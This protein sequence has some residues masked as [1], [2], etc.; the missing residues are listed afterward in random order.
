MTPKSP[1]K[2]DSKALR[3]YKQILASIPEKTWKKET[4]F[5]AGILIPLCITNNKPSILFTVRSSTLR[6]H[7]GEVSFPGGKRDQ[8]DVDI[9]ATA[10]RETEEEISI[11][12]EAVEYLGTFISVP[13]K[14]GNT[15]V[16]SVVGFLGII[17]PDHLQVN[18]EEVERAFTVDIDTL[19]K[20]RE[21]ENFRNTGFMMPSWNVGDDKI[22]GLTGYILG[23][24]LKKVVLND[25][26]SK[27]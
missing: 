24:F 5:E 20:T 17:N 8:E 11:K 27:L 21:T 15:K 6:S 25:S 1:I 13:N 12:P 10:L 4:D 19:L 7:T 14:S 18:P 23:E 16:T 3:N 9:I 22:W 2:F 26:N